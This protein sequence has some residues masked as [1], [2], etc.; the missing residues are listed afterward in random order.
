MENVEDTTVKQEILMHMNQRKKDSLRRYL[1]YFCSMTEWTS[2]N[3]RLEEVNC[4]AMIIAS[5]DLHTIA[6]QPPLQSL[7]ELQPRLVAMDQEAIELLRLSPVTIKEYRYPNQIWQWCL[8]AAVLLLNSLYFDRSILRPGSV[9]HQ[10]LLSWTSFARLLD[11]L[12]PTIFFGMHSIHLVESYFMA[13][14]LSRHSVPPLGIVWWKWMLT[15]CFTGAPAHVR[16]RDLVKA[17][18][19]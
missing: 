8:A 9:L 12:L 14:K 4:N 16:F 13:G 6:F 15:C 5:P 19:C 7:I 10:H 17:E 18:A 11:R 2:R 3:A 1:R